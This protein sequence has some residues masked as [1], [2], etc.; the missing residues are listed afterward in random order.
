MKLLLSHKTPKVD[1][2][3]VLIHE[4]EPLGKEQKKHLGSESTK[5]IEKHLKAKDFEGGHGEMLQLFPNSGSAKKIILLGRGKKNKPKISALEQLGGMAAGA[6]K[7][8]KAKSAAV[9][10]EAEEAHAFGSGFALGNYEFKKYKKEDKKAVNFESLTFLSEANKSSR[11]A[12]QALELFA[13]SSSYVRNLVNTPTGDLNTV[14]LTEEA[15]ALAKKWKLKLTVFDEK[16]LKKLG[17]GSLLSVGRGAEFPPRLL[18][19]EYKHKSKAKHPNLAF[20]GKG[21]V[22]DTGGL[23]IKPTGYIETMKQD[24]AGAATVLGTFQAIAAAKL[25]GYFLG[26]M[27]LAE[28]AVS[29]KATHPG[30][31][32]TSYTG[33]TIEVNNTDA[34]GRLIL[35]DALAYTEDKWKPHAMVD[36]ATLTGA[37]SVALGYNITGI[38]GN[39]HKLLNELKDAAKVSGERVWELPLDDDFVELCKGSFTDLQNATDGVRAGSIMGGAFLKHFVKTTPWVHIDIGG[40]AWAEKPSSSTKHGAT[41][42]GLR[43]LIE[44]G[45]MFSD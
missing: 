29:E 13:E 7:K 19:L 45:K 5:L 41:S 2:L 27:P 28:N 37:V 25:T 18:V 20:V 12:L 3:F 4:G 30:D 34:E 38:M 10:L 9:I 22:F 39:D 21:I 36:I 31:V 14:T 15:Q 43:T 26:V 17:C 32:V 6:S 40:T 8:Y 16:D 1:L 42:A 44:L 11:S 23:N 35:C 33:K 24:M